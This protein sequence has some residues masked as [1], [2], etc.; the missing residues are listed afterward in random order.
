MLKFIYVV[1]I[2]SLYLKRLTFEFTYSKIGIRVRKGDK[3]M[4]KFIV[5]VLAVISILNFAACG[6]SFTP[7]YDQ[8]SFPLEVQITE[9]DG[10]NFEGHTSEPT[11]EVRK[12]VENTYFEICEFYKLD[13]PIPNIKVLDNE[14]FEIVYAENADYAEAFYYKGTLY[15]REDSEKETI[16]H[17]FL[18]Y[19]SDNGKKRGFIYETESGERNNYFNEGATEYL[20]MRMLG[21]PVFGPYDFQRLFAN[22]IALIVGE[23]TFEE[24]Y[25][26]SDDSK[27]RKIF[28]DSVK[29]VYGGY[30]EESLYF[31]PWDEMACNCC[32]IWY[33]QFETSEEYFDLI[34]RNEEEIIYLAL[35]NGKGDEVKAELKKLLT[36]QYG[37]T[38]AE[39]KDFELQY[40]MHMK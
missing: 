25:F 22:Q 18:H 31:D 37:L 3:C 11:I 19:L 10:I 1:H 8:I 33:F 21:R 39:C 29:E 9:D 14:G 16:I 27:V 35:N 12:E 24:A 6:G 20:T 30:K 4:K 40:L 17:E 38:N 15:L 34:T 36:V 2:Y 13:K 23:E 7:K 5:L 26:T 28:N 32:A